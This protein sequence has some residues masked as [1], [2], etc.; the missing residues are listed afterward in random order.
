MGMNPHDFFSAFVEGNYNDFCDERDEANV[1]K[2]INAAVSLF[3]MADQYFNYYK[4]NDPSKISRF[5]DRDDFLKYL[6]SKSK[7]FVDI[8]SIANA[9]KHLYTKIYKT[10][11]TIASTRCIEKIIFEKDKVSIDGC[12][13]DDDGKPVVI[14]TTKDSQK[15]KLIKALD[16]V[17]RMWSSI[18]QPN[19]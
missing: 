6:E 2:G 11:V 19:T 1:R 5:K 17:I 7:Y 16:E 13:E 12:G 14:Y 15:I 18:L 8:Q 10:H 9:Y 3:H 4:K